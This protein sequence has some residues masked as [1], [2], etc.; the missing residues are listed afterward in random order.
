MEHDLL[1]GF[2][3]LHIL[4]HA[5]KGDVFGLWLIKELARHGHEISPGTIYPM[6]HGMEKRGHLASRDK[7]EKGRVRRVYR[8]TASGKKALNEARKRVQELFKELSEE[9]S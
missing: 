9:R 4:Y 8:A 3:R 2:I 7:P 5:A 6:L 1:S